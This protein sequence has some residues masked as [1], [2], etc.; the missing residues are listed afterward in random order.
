VVSLFLPNLRFSDGRWR[1]GRG[2]GVDGQEREL[3]RRAEPPSMPSRPSKTSS[4]EPDR[5]GRGQ[6][7]GDGGKSYLKRL[8]GGPEVF[9]R[10]PDE[11]SCL[12]LVTRIKNVANH[13]RKTLRKRA[14]W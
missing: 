3:L 14:E 11:E 10:N 9:S 1:T 13:E 2:K 4:P 6:A 8:G 7:S 5:G 12:L